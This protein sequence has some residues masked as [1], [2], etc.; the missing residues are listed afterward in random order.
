MKNTAP[1]PRPPEP[2]PLWRRAPVQ[3]GQSGRT[4]WVDAMLLHDVAEHYRIFNVNKG[5]VP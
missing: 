2:N 1:A 4:A 5:R 3:I